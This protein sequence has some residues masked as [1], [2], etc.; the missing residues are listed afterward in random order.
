MAARRASIRGPRARAGI[1]GPGSTRPSS[2][3]VARRMAKWSAVRI[4]S[5]ATSRK[6]RSLPRISSPRRFTCSASTRTRWCPMPWAAPCRLPAT[7]RHAGS[8]WHDFEITKPLPHTQGVVTM[9]KF[10]EFTQ[11]DTKK[12]IWIN[13]DLVSEVAPDQFKPNDVT[14]IVLAGKEKG[15]DV[16]GKAAD[17]AKKLAQ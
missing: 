14:K 15:I 7:A 5:A 10:V 9:A 3:A 1:T 13:P 2:P 16:L 12:Q 11:S 8:C 17:V 6:R 4:G